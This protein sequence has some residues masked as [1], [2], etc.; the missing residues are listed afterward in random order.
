MSRHSRERTS[1]KQKRS[2]SKRRQTQHTAGPQPIR[3]PT[4]AADLSPAERLAWHDAMHALS[5]MRRE[6]LSRAAAAREAGISVEALE[7]YAG[8]AIRRDRSGRYRPSKSDSLLRQI[9]YDTP[10]GPI[11]LDV[12]DSQTASLLGQYAAARGQFLER[13]DVSALRKFRGVR[14]RVGGVSYPLITDPVAI[15]M[16]ARRQTIEYEH[17]KQ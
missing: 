14:I 12:R 15:T 13:G 16:I 10:R 2:R 8:P 6:R 9:R 3:T 17:Y 11:W 4:Q 5:L 7:K 1:R